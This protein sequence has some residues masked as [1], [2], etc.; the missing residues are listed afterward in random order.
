MEII[1]WTKGTRVRAETK[2]GTIR[3][4]V[5]EEEEI[6]RYMY[7]LLPSRGQIDILSISTN[8][9]PSTLSDAVSNHHPEVL[10]LGT[11]K[12]NSDVIEEVQQFRLQNPS[13]GI[14]LFF[15]LYS[16]QD[17]EALRELAANGEGGVAVFLR[18]SLREIEQVL[19]II[20]AVTRGHIV[21]DPTLASFMFGTKPKHPFLEQLTTRE[22]EILNLLSKGGT[23][24]AIAEAL[25]I[26]VK[27]V[28]HH[29]NSMYGK[30]RAE[31]DLNDKHLRVTAARIYLQEVDYQSPILALS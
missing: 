31:D 20:Q 4:F 27:T 28:E 8:C 23:N 25:Y 11:G 29:L 24:G 30:L 3:I 21:L 16:G 12:L 1:T 10:L 22:L 26:D 9:D 13:V 2:S 19:E 7:E 18:Q 17:I 15:S 5:V 6:Y 14:I